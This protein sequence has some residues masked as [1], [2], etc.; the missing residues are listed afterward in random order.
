MLTIVC[1]CYIPYNI[2]TCRV[3]LG[4]SF[5]H[6]LNCHSSTLTP[7]TDYLFKNHTTIH[8]STFSFAICSHPW[9][10]FFF[11]CGV[12]YRGLTKLILHTTLHITPYTFDSITAQTA[13]IRWKGHTTD[14]DKNAVNHNVHRNNV[15]LTII[16]YIKIC[17][18]LNQKQWAQESFFFNCFFFVA[19]LL[20]PQRA[21]S[22]TEWTAVDFRPSTAFSLILLLTFY[23]ECGYTNSIFLFLFGK[24]SQLK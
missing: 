21:D 14:V 19:G 4:S 10:Y 24:G 23:S 17:I 1:Q 12:A 18:C 16:L 5:A 3:W 20:K 11:P 22:I 13:S 7:T 2:P 6:A 8:D 15:K 9:F